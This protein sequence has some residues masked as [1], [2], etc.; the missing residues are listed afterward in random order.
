MP[1]INEVVWYIFEYVRCYVRCY[2]LCACI[3]QLKKKKLF[4]TN[5]YTTLVHFY[6]AIQ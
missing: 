4:F 3:T 1:R 2:V 6:G 5:K